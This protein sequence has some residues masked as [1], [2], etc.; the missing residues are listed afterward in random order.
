MVIVFPFSTEV[1]Q[2]ALAGHSPGA[3]TVYPGNQELLLVANPDSNSITVLD[4]YSTKLVG[5][6]GVGQSP[7]QILYTGGKQPSEQFIL[8][9]N[10]KSGDMAV[11]RMLALTEPQL[12]SKP[13]FKSVS[14]LTMIPVGEGPVSADVVA[15]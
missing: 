10:E 15:L 7:C 1:W 2:T 12:I 6:I 14:L 8:V 4:T 13:R 9:L 11:I 3:M 5:V